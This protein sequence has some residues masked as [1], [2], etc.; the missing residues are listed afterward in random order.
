MSGCGCGGCCCCPTTQPP[1]G[2]GG[3][4]GGEPR[5]TRYRVTFQ[6]IDVSAIDDG[7]L[8]GSLE[9]TWTFVVNGQVQTKILDPLDVGVTPIGIS[10][11]VS[12]PVASSII[13]IAVSGIEDDSFFDDTLPGFVRTFTQNENWGVGT[14]SGSGHDSNITYTMNYD[15][16]CAS[17]TRVAVSRDALI[18]SGRERARTRRN[19]RE[20][21][22]EALLLNWSINRLSRNGWDLAQVVDKDLYMFE[23]Y[24]TPLPLLLEQEP[25]RRQ[26]A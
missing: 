22:D 5:C 12:A 13:D 10:F 4:G 25:P 24:G 7:F 18:T 6:S 14:Q 19:V 1:D 11:F 20:D 9:T 26:G 2:G 21:L 16:G 15:I 3:G 23:G 17:V 8:G